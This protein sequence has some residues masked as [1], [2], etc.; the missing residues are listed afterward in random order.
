MEVKS[1]LSTWSI[2]INTKTEKLENIFI[3][4]MNKKKLIITFCNMHIACWLGGAF[5]SCVLF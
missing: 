5:F 1:T 3:R 4:W 2:D